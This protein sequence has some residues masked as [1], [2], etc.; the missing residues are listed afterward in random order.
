MANTIII[1]NG[2]S[3]PGAGTLQSSELGFDKEN[4][5]LY[6]GLEGENTEPLLVN[7]PEVTIDLDGTSPEE[8]ANIQKPQSPMQY[9]GKSFYPLTSTDQVIMED[10]ARLNSALTG[11][12]YTSEENQESAVVPLNA[13]T[14]GGI[15][16]SDFATKDD[17]GAMSVSVEGDTMTGLLTAPAVALKT[18]GGYSR[19]IRM[20][21]E[22]GSQI[23]SIGYNTAGQLLVR[24]YNLET[25]K[26][27]YYRLPLVTEGLSANNGYYFLTSKEPVT[28]AQ[29]G[30]GAKTVPEAKNNLG[31]GTELWSG[32]WSSGDITVPDT[33]KYTMFLVRI[34]N[35]SAY[36][37]VIKYSNHL[38][39]LGGYSSAESS[40]IT[41]GFSGTFSGDT[42]TFVGAN[43]TVQKSDGTHTLTT[44]SVQKI[45]GLI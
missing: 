20:L 42:W 41:L 11:L 7:P 12:V 10:G 8:V 21:E 16:A 38:R 31:I 27:E 33:D 3:A 40:T 43:S 22:D 2:S 29:G 17:V 14:L 35:Y 1:K 13:D 19:T 6:I 15:P 5:K 28:I 37:P 9:D 18:S 4:K 26:N 25:G 44:R 36:F 32:S 45:I 24:Q 23:G 34:S 39:G 30:T